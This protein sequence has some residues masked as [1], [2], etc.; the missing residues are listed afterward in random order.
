MYSLS[1]L[2]GFD[3]FISSLVE[4]LKNGEQNSRPNPYFSSVCR[5][6]CA[7]NIP[8]PGHFMLHLEGVFRQKGRAD[9]D[10]TGQITVG[11]CIVN[12]L[13]CEASTIFGHLLRPAQEMNPPLAFCQPNTGLPLV[14][15]GSLA[16]QE[17]IGKPTSVGDPP[18]HSLFEGGVAGRQDALAWCPALN[19]F[20]T[21]TR[22]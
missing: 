20:D 18:I 9:G 13:Q 4:K 5:R 21:A 14:A 15:L 22:S 10:S 8:S 16:A 1:S 12:I 3:F 11:T 2:P 19:P 6:I 7:S 17:S